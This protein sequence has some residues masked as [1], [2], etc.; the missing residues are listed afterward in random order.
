M[1]GE[2][3]RSVVAP[4]RCASDAPLWRNCGRGPRGG[5]RASRRA[6][7]RRPRTVRGARVKRDGEH[8]RVWESSRRATQ[9]PLATHAAK[10]RPAAAKATERARAAAAAPPQDGT[11]S[12]N[13]RYN[14]DSLHKTKTCSFLSRMRGCG[15]RTCWPLCAAWRGWSAPGAAIPPPRAAMPRGGGGTGELSLCDG[16]PTERRGL[17]GTSPGTA[18]EARG[19]EGSRYT[20]ALPL[21][22]PTENP[23]NADNTRETIHS[24]LA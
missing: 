8:V 15:G 3:V 2:A 4:G 5:G 14:A 13:R 17:Y 12:W 7:R 6:S 20:R 18:R 16:R 22:S 9:I 11:S 1:R 10:K 24:A 19:R 21:R 23:T